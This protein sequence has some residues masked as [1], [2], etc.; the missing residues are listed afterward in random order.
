MQ[1]NRSAFGFLQTLIFFSIFELGIIGCSSKSMV[2][3]IPSIDKNIACFEIASFGKT[4]P[5]FIDANADEGIIRTMKDLQT[6]VQ[7]VTNVEPELLRTKLPKSGKVIIVG[8]IGY[9]PKIDQLIESGKLNVNGVDGEWEAYVHQVVQNPFEGIDE[10]LVIAGSDKRGTI[11]GI[12]DIS[13][14][15]G[16]SPWHFWADVPTPKKETVSVVPGCRVVDKPSVQYR[17]IFLNDENPALYG[18]VNETYGGFNHEFYEDVFELI[19][20]LKGNYLWTAMWGKAFYDDDPENAPIADMY[21]V[22]IGTTHHEPMGRAHVEWDRY[23]KNEWNYQTNEEFLKKF[24]SDGIKRLKDYEATISLGMRGDGDMAMSEETNIELMERIVADQRKIIEEYSEQAPDK[25]VQLWAL[26]KEVQDYYEQGMQIPDDVMLLLA[27]DNWGNV[28]LLPEPGKANEHLGG[29]GVYYHFDYVG[30]PRNYKWINTSQISRVWE[31]MNVSFEHGVDRMWL[32]NVGDLKPMEFPISFF[33]DHA[34][35]PEKM[36]VKEMENYPVKWA[37]SQFGATYAEKIGRFLNEYTRFNARRKPE[38]LNVPPNTPFSL[39]HF[40]EFESV[41]DDYTKL[42]EEAREVYNVISEGYRDAYYQ[43]VM[44]PIE[45]SANL[46]RLYFA[47]AK[48]KW[49]ATQGRALTNIMADRV[50]EFFDKDAEITNYYHTEIADGKWNHMMSQTH[51]GYTY[52]QQP[53]QNNIPETVRIELPE[54]ASMGI[55][56]EGSVEAG[57]ATLPTFDRFNKQSYYV[58]I[59][60][61]GTTSFKYSIEASV[62][63]VEFSELSSTI[64]DQQRIYVN[65]DWE[66][67]PTGNTETTF[68]I[69]SEVGEYSVD[70]EIFN[71]EN[72]LDSFN[73]FIEA[74]GFISIEAENY[75]NA[76]STEE[77]TWMTIPR[78][79]KTQSAVTTSPSTFRDLIPGEDSNLRLEYDT[80]LFNPGQI[81]VKLMLSPTLQFN[82][83]KGLKVAVS[84]D[85]QEPQIIN[86]H[87]SYNWNRIVGDAI[88]IIE[89]DHM[90]EHS[91]AHTLKIWPVDGGVVLQK[92]VIE[93]EEIG[94][95]YLGPPESFKMN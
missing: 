8:T 80:Y 30:G 40:N 83:S 72:T 76:I 50:Q 58:E 84:F 73:G 67:V 59:F 69:K 75:S 90:I 20:R 63:W 43:L 78:L 28:R 12:Y 61:K 91:G 22:V 9:S 19:L 51:I 17:G 64:T 94:S 92:M 53:E 4:I 85:N 52:W 82:Q 41:V 14:Q 93:T 55:S 25:E 23:G 60:N 95:T 46:Y 11:F 2:E 7:R 35:S 5:L 47:V 38:L 27:D 62:P 3:P 44:H 24:W 56:V 81:T 88:H 79:G 31:Q 74:N 65:I 48:N 15:M 86:I 70:L 16:V 13:E 1:I 34:W 57:N 87:E 54:T 39:V 66:N 37:R 49:Y 6:D 29:W 68:T 45:A 33:L 10:A 71:P 77:V 18:W 21:G 26:Y 36:G 32:V 42:E 89:T